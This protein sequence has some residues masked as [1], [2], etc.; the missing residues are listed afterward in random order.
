[1]PEG[2]SGPDVLPVKSRPKVKFLAM[3]RNF[4]DAV[5]SLIPFF[6][7]HSEEFRQM[8]GG[9]P[10]TSS[11]DK[12]ASV[13]ERLTEVLPGGMLSPLYFGYVNG[14]WPL[15]NEP[16]VLL[17]HYADA[18]RDRAGTVAKIAAFMNVDLTKEQLNKIVHL[19]SIEEMRKLTDHFSY[20]LPL[21]QDF[22][23][24]VMKSGSMTRKGAVGE[25]KVVFSAEQQ[26]RA[27]AAEEA[28]FTD[29]A[30]L[31]WAR[32]GGGFD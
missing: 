23:G 21:N 31:N 4:L 8:W 17:L 7:S 6:D 27:K 10:P 29:P 28:Q 19:T 26:A 20:C 1:M 16:N 13:E 12:A 2:D 18:K 9:F 5:A 3:S 24:K 25:G 11:A 30:L 22:H 14:W 15:R 32:N